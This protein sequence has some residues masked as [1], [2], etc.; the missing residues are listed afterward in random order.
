MDSYSKKL[1]YK[2]E[3]DLYLSDMD[4]LMDFLISINV[5]RDQIFSCYYCDITSINF[6]TKLGRDVKE[7]FDNKS[8]SDI[9]RVIDGIIPIRFLDGHK[10]YILFKH[11]PEARITRHYLDDTVRIYSHLYGYDVK[12]IV[13]T[14]Y[15]YV[16][17]GY[18]NLRKN[19]FLINS[20]NFFKSET[21]SDIE[22][23][24][25]KDRIRI[26]NYIKSLN[27]LNHTSKYEDT[28]NFYPI[29]DSE[30]YDVLLAVIIGI[31]LSLGLT[32]LC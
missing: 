3:W 22:D 18:K 19:R 29:K 7:L 12:L 24:M 14:P 9:C 31:L 4:N 11:I 27:N 2:S 30:K 6:T 28:H 21:Y 13:T 8:K 32:F 1:I 10:C 25:E 26:L 23:N 15:G 16:A 20:S 17:N 5:N